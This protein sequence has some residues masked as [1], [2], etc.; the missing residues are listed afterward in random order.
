M[1]RVLNVP[2]RSAMMDQSKERMKSHVRSDRGT[3]KGRRPKIISSERLEYMEAKYC[4]VSRV[5]LVFSYLAV[6]RD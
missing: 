3:L 2:V 5:A 4:S 1:T 6:G